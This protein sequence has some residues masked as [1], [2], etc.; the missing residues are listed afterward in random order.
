MPPDTQKDLLALHRRHKEFFGEDGPPE[1][2]RIHDI[3]QDQAAASLIEQRRIS[4]R[5]GE[6]LLSSFR[7][8]APC[9]PFVQIP[10]DATVPSLSKSSPFLLLA[11][12]TSASIKDPPLY[13]QMVSQALEADV[14]LSSGFRC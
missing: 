6:E 2:R 10:Q 7:L 5:D 8:M 13:H 9:F 4:L 11:I 14:S 12:L 1:T 3:E